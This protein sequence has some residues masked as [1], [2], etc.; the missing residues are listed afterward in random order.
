[1]SF[2]M[3]TFSLKISYFPL[4]VKDSESQVVLACRSIVIEA[5]CVSHSKFSRV[6][7]CVCLDLLCEIIYSNFNDSSPSK[8]IF[9]SWKPNTKW[10][11]RLTVEDI[12]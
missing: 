7:V 3:V 4:L 6:C 10:S 2:P 8:R 9:F 12:L 1:M 5:P 11:V